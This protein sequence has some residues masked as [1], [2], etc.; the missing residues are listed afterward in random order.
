VGD[1]S[2]ACQTADIRSQAAAE[3][4]GWT[5]VRAPPGNLT[6]GREPASRPGR[7]IYGAAHMAWRVP[8]ADVTVTDADVEVVVEAL[9]SGWLSMG[10]RTQEFEAAFAAY[11]GVGHAVAV[12]NGTAA[13]HL[14]YAA[15]GLGPGD[16]VVVPSLTFV[17]TVNAARYV[18]ATPVFADIVSEVE[19]WLDPQAVERAIGPRTKAIVHMPYG[20]HPGSLA[21]LEEIASRHGLLLLQDAAHA[22]GARL[23]ER[24]LGAVGAAAAFSFFSNKNLA[25]GE[26][27]MVATDDEEL[28]RRVRLLRSHGMTALSWD[29]SRGHASGYDVVALG[30]NYRIDDPRAALGRH[31]LAS[32]DADNARRAEHDAAYR[33]ALP[34]SVRAA[35]APA[36]GVTPAHHLFTIVVDEGADREELRRRLADE[37]VQTSVHYPPVHGFSAFAGDAAPPLPVTESYAARAVSLPMFAHMTDAQRDLVVDSVAAA[38]LEIA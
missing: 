5:L 24:H 35:L 26:G 27:G 11:L 18:G 37:G 31:R 7:L 21:A 14:M 22:I 13:L 19:P 10:P 4:G 38:T 25:I 17:A 32:L 28:A 12:A 9:R 20:G 33:R 30:F 29:R 6:D 34:G 36:D 16:E 1:H 3:T 2:A 8:L 23:G 15:A